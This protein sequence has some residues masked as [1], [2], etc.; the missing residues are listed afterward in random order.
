MLVSSSLTGDEGGLSPVLLLLLMEKLR[1]GVV[2]SC[3]QD[4]GETSALDAQA[5]AADV[6]DDDVEESILLATLPFRRQLRKASMAVV[7]VVVVL[8][9]LVVGWSPTLST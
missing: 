3:I 6:D 8:A 9:E 7:V 1:R 4:N 2:Y 5:E